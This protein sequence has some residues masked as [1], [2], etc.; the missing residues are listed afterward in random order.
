MV[1]VPSAESLSTPEGAANSTYVHFLFGL[2]FKYK[3]T[4]E[5]GLCA[6]LSVGGA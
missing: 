6:I 3:A 4:T 5:Q 1:L 2:I